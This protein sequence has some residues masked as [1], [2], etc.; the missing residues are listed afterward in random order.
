MCLYLCLSE[1]SIRELQWQNW[2]W[3]GGFSTKKIEIYSPSFIIFPQTSHLGIS[4][5][6][7]D[8]SIPAEVPWTLQSLV[9]VSVVR[10]IYTLKSLNVFG[11]PHIN[12]KCFSLLAALVTE[13]QSG[14]DYV[15]LLT[16]YSFPSLSPPLSSLQ[17]FCVI[18]MPLMVRAIRAF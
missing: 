1:L 17:E 8:Q 10:V 5:H 15:L 9:H 13:L 11:A 18:N 3:K 4:S 16:P 2:E 6:R 14:L 12:D 7:R